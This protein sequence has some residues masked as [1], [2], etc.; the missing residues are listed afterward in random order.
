MGP[1]TAASLF[2]GIFMFSLGF[3]MLGGFSDEAGQCRGTTASSCTDYKG[4]NSDALKYTI[5]MSGNYSDTSNAGSAPDSSLYVD[6][7]KEYMS[8]QTTF[9]LTPQGYSFLFRHQ[10]VPDRGTANCT[11]AG[12]SSWQCLEI[13]SSCSNGVKNLFQSFSCVDPIYSLKFTQPLLGFAL[14][15]ILAGTLLVLGSTVYAILAISGCNPIENRLNRFKQVQS[16]QPQPQAQPSVAVQNIPTGGNDA[17]KQQTD[18]EKGKGNILSVNIPQVS[19]PNAQ[20]LQQQVPPVQLQSPAYPGVGGISPRTPGAIQAGSLQNL[21]VQ[22][23]SPA[24][25]SPEPLSQ[26]VAPS[27]LGPGG[28][29]GFGAAGALGAAG[30]VVGTMK[31]AG[32]GAVGRVGGGAREYGEALGGRAMDMGGEISREAAGGWGG[33]GNGW[34]GEIPSAAS[35]AALDLQRRQKEREREKQRER[36]ELDALLENRQRDRERERQ[37]QR[38]REELDARLEQKYR[39]KEMEREREQRERQRERQQD[40]DR[41]GDRDRERERDRL[42]RGPRGGGGDRERDRSPLSMSDGERGREYRERD[43]DRGGEREDPR[44]QQQRSA[45]GGGGARPYRDPLDGYDPR[46]KHTQ[47]MASD[48]RGDR[49]DAPRGPPRDR[50]RDRGA[51][52]PSGPGRRE[53]E[54]ERETDPVRQRERERDRSPPVRGESRERHAEWDRWGEKDRDRDRGGARDREGEFRGVTPMR[55]G[56]GSGAGV[57]AEDLANIPQARG[58]VTLERGQSGEYWP[59]S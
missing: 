19:M 47:Q 6:E 9:P 51:P 56:D 1:L 18:I 28:V 13:T 12:C 57:S 29:A 11:L 55:V 40:R 10:N 20:Q 37:K 23:P 26:A 52:S 5:V 34:G 16:P 36:E 27:P 3:L 14:A 41:G 43:R 8:C 21:Q 31:T 48:S 49:G 46:E 30:G 2:G 38:E 33:A 45:G 35:P 4:S 24:R 25:F 59:E 54:R 50:D 39:D 53:R 44:Q 32:E 15:L 42:M 7:I 17:S 58:S 22:T